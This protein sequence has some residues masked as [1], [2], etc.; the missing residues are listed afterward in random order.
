MRNTRAL[1][2]VVCVGAL[3]TTGLG[4]GTA[5]AST[6]THTLGFSVVQLATYQTGSHDIT[7]GKDVQNGRVTGTDVVT[8]V[9]NLATHTASCDAAVARTDGIIYAHVNVSLSTGS[10]HGN[11]TGGTRAFEGATG[12]IA[13]TPGPAPNTNRV[14]ITYQN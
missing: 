8:C 1:A 9:A 3:A 13:V 7:A 10:G 11:V 5:V 4:L 2:M 6:E 12:S 14:R